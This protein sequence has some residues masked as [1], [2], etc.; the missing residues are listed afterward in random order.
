MSKSID[1]LARN[2]AGGMSR[3]KA[4][5]QFFSGLGVVAAVT[6]SKTY[7][8]AFNGGC[9]NYCEAQADIFRNLCMEASQTC[10]S[11][12]CADISVSISENPVIPSTHGPL[13]VNSGGHG[14]C[15]N[16]STPGGDYTCVPVYIP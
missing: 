4:I 9:A 8:V 7:A 15:F 10:C 2:L 14:V 5:W 13:V 11:G 12:Y 6:G 1:Q 3:R 16:G